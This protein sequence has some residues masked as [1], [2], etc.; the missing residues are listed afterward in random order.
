MLVNSVSPWESAPWS[1]ETQ[2]TVQGGPEHKPGQRVQESGCG[3]GEIVGA[4]EWKAG[5]MGEA[6]E[7]AGL[8]RWGQ[9]GDRFKGRHSAGQRPH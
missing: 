7:R 3:V 5:V 6:E 2:L 1:E 8:R 9:Q 4:V